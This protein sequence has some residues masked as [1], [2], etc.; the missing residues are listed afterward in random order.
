MEGSGGNFLPMNLSMDEYARFCLHS[1]S[2]IET[3]NSGDAGLN[4]FITRLSPSK[5]YLTVREEEEEEDI[6]TV[7]FIQ[8]LRKRNRK[9]REYLD[10]MFAEA[11]PETDAQIYE[12]IRESME[13]H[14]VKNNGS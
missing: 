9:L 11:G 4:R 2:N 1:V 13:L 12:A 6:S 10:K 5:M 14:R 7:S 8:T 3:Y